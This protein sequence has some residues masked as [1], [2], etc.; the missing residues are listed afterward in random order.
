M[1]ARGRRRWTVVLLIAT[2]VGLLVGLPAAADWRVIPVRLDLSA[3]TKSGNIKVVNDT[4]EP[5]RFSVGASRWTQD[6][7]GK[8][9]YDPTEDLVFFPRILIVPP[10]EERI[11]RAGIK[12][13]ATDVEGTYRLFIEQIPERQSA[14]ASTAVSLAI[15]FGAPVF[16]KPLAP[17]HLARLDNL[18]VEAGALRFTLVNAGNV[19]LQPTEITATGLGSGP[20]PLFVQNIDP[21]Y[22]LAGKSRPYDVALTE[23]CKGAQKLKLVLKSEEVEI[24]QEIP[25]TGAVCP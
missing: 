11:I 4:K 25:L 18:R 5:I 22:L 10:G 17:A 9:H 1:L 14:D 12:I 19:H 21:W 6:E 13:P 20:E 16:S 2:V 7:N 3:D 24:S 15:R 8:D 23:G